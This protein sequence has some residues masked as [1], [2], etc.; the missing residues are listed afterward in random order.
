VGRVP[1]RVLRHVRLSADDDRTLRRTPAPR[2]PRDDEEGGRQRVD[3]RTRTAGNGSAAGLDGVRE[4]RR[5]SEGI[6]GRRAG[7]LAS[8]CRLVVTRMA[9]LPPLAARPAAGADG[10]TRSPFPAERK[11]QQRDSRRV[12]A[13]GYRCSIHG[14]LPGDRAVPDEHGAAQVPAADLREAGR[15]PGGR[16]VRAADLHEGA[17]DVPPC[18]AGHHR[19]D[20]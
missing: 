15:A 7:L 16:R 1:A 6:R 8:G 3:I 14:R 19:P 12:V 4:G 5:R 17:P 18:F 11:R 13:E 20:I 2:T 10:R 9:A